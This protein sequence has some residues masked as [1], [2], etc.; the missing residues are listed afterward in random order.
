MTNNEMATA[1][2]AN[3][4][5]PKTR[6]LANKLGQ[7]LAEDGMVETPI[8]RV[9]VI[10]NN[11]TTDIIHLVHE[12]AVCIVA[13]G[14]KRV[15]LGEE[16][17]LYGPLHYLVISV[18]LPLAG[19]VIE[20]SADE[21]YLCL[22][23]DL[24]PQEIGELML[25]KHMLAEQQSSLPKALSRQTQRGMYLSEADSPLLDAAV[26]LMSLLDTPRDIAALAPLIIREIQYRLLQSNQGDMLRQIALSES[27]AQQ[28]AKV[29][30]VLK[31]DYQKS[32]SI[33][34]LARVACMS[35]SSLHA[36]FKSITAMSPLQYQ[37]QLRLQEARRMLLNDQVDAATAGHRVGYESPSQFSRE[38]SRLFGLPPVRDMERLR[39]NNYVLQGV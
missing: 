9:H 18:D 12:P 24:N 38:Y 28:I 33:D 6:E 25:A 26:R 30:R 2:G 39:A 19:Q 8:K 37:K 17:Y 21:P 14:R 35:T 31:S 36:H 13:Q 27:H 32:L 20:A 23:L 11:S 16:V 29:I 4:L 34:E 15:M 7:F 1:T 22:R 5:L 10:R 3:P